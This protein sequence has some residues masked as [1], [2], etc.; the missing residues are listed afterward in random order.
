MFVDTSTKSAMIS[1][2]LRF[3]LCIRRDEEQRQRSKGALQATQDLRTLLHNNTGN[4]TNIFHSIIPV[5]YKS[6][7]V[8]HSNS[9]ENTARC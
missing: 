5:L 6:Y 8:Y 4:N 2:G 1:R 7:M 9:I 3:E